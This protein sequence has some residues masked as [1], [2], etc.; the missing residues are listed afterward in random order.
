MY[1]VGNAA[2]MAFKLKMK[3]MKQQTDAEILKSE[4]KFNM[5]KFTS[6]IYEEERDDKLSAARYLLLRQG[7]DEQQFSESYLH[8]TF[9]S[10][11]QQVNLMVIREF[12]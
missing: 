5:L 7:I 11:E 10:G 8:L 2:V 1:N 6:H 4:L 9:L 12:N 3:E